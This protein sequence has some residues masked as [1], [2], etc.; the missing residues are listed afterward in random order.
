MEWLNS[1]KQQQ[2]V[3]TE[4]RLL[5]V[6]ELLKDIVYKTDHDPE[7]R[8]KI[9]EARKKEID[10][11][12]EQIKNQGVLPYD[13]TQIKE[14]FFQLEDTVRKLLSDF[15]QVEHNFRKLDRETR[16][17]IA[18]SDKTKGALLDG[19]FHD[20]DAIWDSDQGKSLQ[21]QCTSHGTAWKIP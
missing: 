21:Y 10:E 5:T 13:S 20:Q 15:R 1:L 19:I 16:E 6:F 2:F 7:N 14:G 3:G 17:H 9:L 11:E 4:S 18:K 12:I 8:I